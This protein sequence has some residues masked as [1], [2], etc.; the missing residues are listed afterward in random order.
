MTNNDHPPAD[1][2]RLRALLDSLTD[3]AVV[4]DRSEHPVFDLEFDRESVA[5]PT[6]IVRCYSKTI[7]TAI[8]EEHILYRTGKSMTHVGHSVSGWRTF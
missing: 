1:R 3:A 6:C 5:V 4:I 7:H 8:L 2:G